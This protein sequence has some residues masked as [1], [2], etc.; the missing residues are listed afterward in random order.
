MIDGDW[1]TNEFSYEFVLQL[2]IASPQNCYKTEL[3]RA[4]QSILAALKKRKIK[5]ISIIGLILKGYLKIKL[6]LFIHPLVW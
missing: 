5:I 3:L 4:I 6:S 1:L 2:H